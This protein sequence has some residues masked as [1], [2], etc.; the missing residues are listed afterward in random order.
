MHITV[1]LEEGEIIFVIVG[2]NFPGFTWREQTV[3]NQMRRL[4]GLLLESAIAFS[5]KF[6]I[7]FRRASFFQ[8][9]L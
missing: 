5:V 1:R 6:E 2:G 4:G 8:A 7:L 9:V 3:T